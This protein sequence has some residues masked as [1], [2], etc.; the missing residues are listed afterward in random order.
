MALVLP[1]APVDSA[2]L[3]GGAAAGPSGAWLDLATTHRLVDETRWFGRLEAGGS[4]RR[5]A[6]TQA[7]AGTIA[8]PITLAGIALAMRGDTATAV[9]MLRHAGR[10]A[11]D[12]LAKAALRR[13]AR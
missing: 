3:V 5:D 12:S 4:A 13:L 2:R 10:L 7:V 6:N 9:N 1:V 8:T 11:D